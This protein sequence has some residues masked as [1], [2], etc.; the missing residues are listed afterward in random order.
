MKPIFNRTPLTPNTLS[1]LPL[2]SIRPEDWLREQLTIQRDGLTA[3][4][5]ERWDAVGPAC[6][7]L[8]GDG[9]CGDRAPYYLE[10]REVYEC[11]VIYRAPFDPA[12]F[13]EI[14]Q[15]RYENFP[16]G[17]HHMYIGKIVSARRR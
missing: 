15:K 4:L 9:D 12:G 16:A 13:G 8:G 6:G 14:P 3:H 7:W 2:G 10:A 11:E 1:P 5:D 17:I